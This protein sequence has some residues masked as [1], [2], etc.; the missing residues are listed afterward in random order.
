[1]KLH[2][3]TSGKYLALLLAAWIIVNS[4]ILW[5]RYEPIPANLQLTVGSETLQMVFVKGGTFQLGESEEVLEGE[6]NFTRKWLAE[7]MPKH[8]VT[9]SDY[10][11]G[12]CEVTQGLWQEV[13]GNNPSAIKGKHL[14]VTN[15]SWHEAQLFIEALSQRTGRHFRLPTDAEWVYAARGGEKQS[16]QRY[17]GSNH[18]YEVAWAKGNAGETVH[19]VM[20]KLPNSLGIYDMCGNVMEWCHDWYGPYPNNSETNP[21]GCPIGEYKVAHGGAWRASEIF[22]LPSIRTYDDPAKGYNYLG[23]RLVLDAST[24]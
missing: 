14:P 18:L 22:C 20:Q 13:M 3:T 10:Y 5:V 19:N 11:I 2:I 8:Q 9:L 12:A 16:S 1:M 21:K 23:F 7:Q 17:A 15:V 4:I 6:D 24:Y